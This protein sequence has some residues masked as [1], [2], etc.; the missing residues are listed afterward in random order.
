MLDFSPSSLQVGC[1][2]ATKVGGTKFSLI[3]GDRKFCVMGPGGGGAE[4][5][6][7]S[8]TSLPSLQVKSAHN[9]RL[10]S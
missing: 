9:R 3:E 6:R 5:K 2:S 4:G 10:A 8:S 1:D 7:T